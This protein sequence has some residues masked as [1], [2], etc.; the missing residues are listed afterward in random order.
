MIGQSSESQSG[1]VSAPPPEQ[2][3]SLLFT[4]YFVNL[5]YPSPKR[6]G[7]RARQ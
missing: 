5:I 3:D 7:G 4:E 2:S 1:T 6:S